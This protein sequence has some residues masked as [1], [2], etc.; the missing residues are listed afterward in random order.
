MKYKN[1]ELNGVRTTKPLLRFISRQV[2]R[3]IE[4]QQSLLFL[5]RDSSYTVSI[6]REVSEPYF[7]CQLEVKIGS[8]KW[9]SAQSGKSIQMALSMAI[10]HLHLDVQYVDGS[11]S[12]WTHSRPLDRKEN[13]T[14]FGDVAS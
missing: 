14:I 10:K 2:E 4:R 5:S 13:E 11:V 8:R 12:G 6:D 9:V 1:I 3:W 7:S